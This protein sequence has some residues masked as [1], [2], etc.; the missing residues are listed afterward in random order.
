VAE[1]MIKIWFIDDE[2]SLVQGREMLGL[3]ADELLVTEPEGDSFQAALQEAEREAFDLIL[4]D[5]ELWPSQLPP[6][7]VDGVSLVASLRSWARKRDVNLP[8]V[9]ILTNQVR[10]FRNDIPAIGAWRPIS[11]TFVN[12]EALIGR[13]LDVEW[14]LTKQDPKLSEK[15]RDLADSLAGARAVFQGRGI[16]LDELARYVAVPDVVWREGAVASLRQSRPPV[17]E[18]ETNDPVLQRAPATALLWLLQRALSF[19]GL[20]VSDFY[21]AT[22]L[23]I[24]P[25]ALEAALQRDKEGEL[26][27]MVYTGP[28]HSLIDRR[29]WS[30]GLNYLTLKADQDGVSTA[31]MIGASEDDLLKIV[32]PVVVLDQTLCEDGISPVSEAV[33]V[34]PPGWPSEAIQPWMKRTDTAARRWLT[35]MVDVSDVIG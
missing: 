33:R 32:D 35:E 16:S 9:V 18:D 5:E 31:K 11:D 29:W 17:T 24:R 8:G 14:L 13:T 21:A 7:A 25:E 15:V 30:A 27:N 10:A 2:V 23:G 19:P 6:H 34:Q 26:A 20:F 12:H 4:M 3:G 1:E 22:A 28:L